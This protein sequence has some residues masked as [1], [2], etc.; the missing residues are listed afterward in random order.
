MRAPST[1]LTLLSTVALGAACGVGGVPEGEGAGGGGG[2]GGDGSGGNALQGEIT[3]DLALSGQ[4]EFNADATI[5]AGATVTIAA[6]SEVSASE[7]VSITVHGSLQILGTADS[8]ITI[9]PSAGPLL[10]T[11][12]VQGA[13]SGLLVESGGSVKLSHVDGS[14]VATLVYC[15][16]GALQC[17]LEAIGFN[18]VGNI[19]VAE[20]ATSIVASN[21]ETLGTISVRGTGSLDIVDSRI[22]NSGH[23]I[24]VA[25]G[26]DLRIDHSE[27]GGATGS[28]EHCNLHIGA[29]NS[30]NVTNSNITSAVYGL[31]I[32]GVTG[33]VFNNNNFTLNESQDVLEV[34]TVSDI[35]LSGN[36]WA[37]GAP[38]ALGDN[39]DVSGPLAVEVADAGPRIAL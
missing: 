22:F 16:S 1:L 23:D 10:P 35:D 19:V 8:R 36:Y 31:M 34:G 12:A 21:I 11:D 25:S 32:G 17:E 30:V 2:G 33:A 13:W 24:I 38:E 7:G 39:Y 9:H 27:I 26:G 18:T 15:K 6:G 29:A 5:A 20:A 37:N 14:G 3:E 28:Y 4:I